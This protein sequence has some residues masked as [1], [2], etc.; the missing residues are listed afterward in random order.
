MS[1]CSNVRALLFRTLM[2]Q[3]AA[4]AMWRMEEFP[5]ENMRDQNFIPIKCLETPKFSNNSHGI[6]D[7]V[8]G[9]EECF[10][11]TGMVWQDAAVAIVPEISATALIAEDDDRRLLYL[12]VIWRP[13]PIITAGFSIKTKLT[14]LFVVLL[15]WDKVDV[16]LASVPF[17]A[18]MDLQQTTFQFS[19][20]SE[21]PKLIAVHP[22]PGV[23]L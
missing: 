14:L 21:C 7:C 1:L 11:T 9:R 18:V 17:R 20:F 12:T 16:M 4:L 6:T 23:L 19:I 3:C 22:V 10:F 2:S 8:G 5:L 15:V 13:P